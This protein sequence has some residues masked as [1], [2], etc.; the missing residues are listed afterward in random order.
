MCLQYK[1][2]DLQDVGVVFTI[3]VGYVKLREMKP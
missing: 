1:V 3:H 2:N